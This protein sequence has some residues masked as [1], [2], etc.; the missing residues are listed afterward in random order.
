[1]PARRLW[2][3][4]LAVRPSR[5]VALCVRAAGEK[6]PCIGVRG[7]PSSYIGVFGSVLMTTSEYFPSLA[8]LEG[9]L[10]SVRYD[11]RNLQST[12]YC[13]CSVACWLGDRTQ[14][15]NTSTSSRPTT[16]NS[17][18][19]QL[20]MWGCALETLETR[21]QAVAQLCK[22]WSLR[23]PLQKW[24]LRRPSMRPSLP[25][26]SQSSASTQCVALSISSCKRC[27]SPSTVLFVSQ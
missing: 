21:K 2:R 18:H 5:P 6:K 13:C 27:L 19:K 10:G 25:S 3:R 11:V 26:L 14:T 16:S 1:M 23:R 7:C 24:S 15:P 9:R 12:P 22:T 4:V 20:K 8:S 17:K